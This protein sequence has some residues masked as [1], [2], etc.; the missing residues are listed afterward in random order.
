MQP[1]PHP[2]VLTGQHENSA[3][4]LTS[5]DLGHV[6]WMSQKEPWQRK[7]FRNNVGYWKT[8]KAFFRTALAKLYH[9][10]KLSRYLV[11]VSILLQQV[12]LGNWQKLKH[13]KPSIPS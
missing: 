1:Y 8:S 11:T 6:L 9:V 4:P 2:E 10:N 3:S 7:N 5:C 12:S 13:K